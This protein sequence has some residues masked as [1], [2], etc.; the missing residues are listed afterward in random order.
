MKKKFNIIFYVLIGALSACNEYDFNQEQ[1]RNEVGL[2][3]NS[4]LIYNRQVANIGQEKDT[5]Y[6][7]AVISGSQIS[8]ST[9]HVALIESDSLL[10]AYNKSNFDL[11]KEKYAKLLPN[12]CYDF[13]NTELDIQAGTSKVMFPIYLKNLDRISPDSIYFLDYKIDPDKT[14]NYNPDK[15][16][17][18]LSIYKENYFATTKTPTYYNYTSSTITIPRDD[19]SYE[20]R[21]PTNANQVFPIGANSVR[22]MAGDEDYGDYKTARSRI[23]SKSIILEI[24][25]QQPENPQARG[26]TIRAHDR[27][28]DVESNPIDV[29][30]LN[31]S[32]DYDNTFL[33]NVIRTPDGRATYYKEFRLHYKYRLQ[34]SSPY[35]EVKAKLR[36]EF[37]PRADKL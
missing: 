30:Q 15:S 3:S 24:G 35:R 4:S 33:L 22:M 27:V 34:S 32:E 29:E 23:I 19:G 17:V 8:T 25:E 11:E 37:N 20:V 31:P 7:V 13:P 21:R 26:L 16:H 36:Y 6:L 10:Q 12:E 14:P 2:L 9:H 18:L 5:I 28:N 1:Y